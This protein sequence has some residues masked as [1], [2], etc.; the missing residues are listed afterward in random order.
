MKGIAIRNRSSISII[1]SLNSKVR[2]SQ[3]TFRLYE[4]VRFFL[5]K[6]AF[7][8]LKGQAGEATFFPFL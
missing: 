7:D 5:L 3:R 6:H 2:L 4:G 1:N 8:V